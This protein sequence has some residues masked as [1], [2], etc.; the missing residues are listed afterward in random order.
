METRNST[1][2]V[3]VHHSLC[4]STH[5]SICHIFEWR[6]VFRCAC[7][8]CTSIR[9]SVHPLV[10]QP[11]H[12]SVCPLVLQLVIIA[13]SG[14]LHCCPCPSARD[15]GAVN[16]PCSLFPYSLFLLCPIGHSI[17]KLCWDFF[18]ANASTQFR[19]ILLSPAPAQGHVNISLISSLL[20][21]ILMVYHL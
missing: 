5:P 10:S 9:G 15:T 2:A 4:P 7:Q 3:L 17:T 16:L 14:L 21:L 13:S 1:F 6:A 19:L 20:S 11:V 12:P 18:H 8:E